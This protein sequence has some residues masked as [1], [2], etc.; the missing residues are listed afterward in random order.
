MSTSILKAAESPVIKLRDQLVLQSKALTMVDSGIMI[1]D[2]RGRIM[3]VNP[4]FSTS[5]GYAVEEIVGK[6]PRILKSGRHDE[7]FYR[8]FWDTILSGETWRGQFINRRRDGSLCLL[9][10]T[11][12][13]IRWHSNGPVTHFI[14]VSKD[15]TDKAARNPHNGRP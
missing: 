6:T 15:I 14:S 4:A 13:P 12:T 9:A 2:H 7:A 5:T 3:W 11:T 8:Q 1:T 10:Q